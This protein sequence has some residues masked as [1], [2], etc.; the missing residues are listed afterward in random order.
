MNI[1]RPGHNGSRAGGRKAEREG[2]RVGRETHGGKRESLN[3]GAERSHG[4]R[5]AATDRRH[6]F[7]AAVEL[8]MLV[9]RQKL[10]VWDVNV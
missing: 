3:Q 8:G 7:P 1:S 6:A 9:Y 5:V 2:G 10:D 4:D